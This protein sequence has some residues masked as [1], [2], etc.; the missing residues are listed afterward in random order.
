MNTWP[1]QANYSCGNF[2]DTSCL[3]P[4]RSEGLWRPAFTVCIRTENQDQASS[5]SSAPWEVSVLP[6]LALGHHLQVY[7]LSQTPHLALALAGHL[8]PEMSLP[9]PR[10][11]LSPPLRLTRSVKKW[12]EYFT[13]GLQGRCTP[14][15]SLADTGVV[16]CRGPPTYPIPLISLH[17]ARLESVSTGFSLPADSAKPVPLAVVSLDSR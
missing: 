16:G 17:R 6:E 1:P 2:S 5:C 12:S 13:G 10:T 9:L 11:P 14:P 4:Q 15:R 8:V 3:K 7:G